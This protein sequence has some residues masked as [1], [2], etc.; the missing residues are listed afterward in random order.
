MGRKALE[1]VMKAHSGRRSE[2]GKSNTAFNT[3]PATLSAAPIGKTHLILY[4]NPMDGTLTVAITFTNE[5]GNS[6]ISFR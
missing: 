3:I 4:D 6:S 2:P 5:L 1:T